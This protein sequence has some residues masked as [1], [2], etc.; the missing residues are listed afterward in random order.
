MKEADVNVSLLIPTMNRSDFLIR[1]LRYYRDL[2]FQGCICIGDS[3]EPEHV[4]RTKRVIKALQDEINI[5]Y[6]EY[7]DLSDPVC[8]QQLLDFVPTPYAAYVA[9]DDFL[10]PSALERCARFLHSHPDYSAA[11][12]VAAVFSLQS[13]GAHGQIM[14]ADR[15]R[16]PVIE[17]GSASQRLVD[18]LG[19]YSVA[20]FSVHPIEAWEAEHRNISL[21]T[22]TSFAGE[23]LPGCLSVI[24][25]KVKELDCLYLVRQDH[26]RRYLLPGVI[27][28]ITSPDWLP[29]YQI[30]RDR[31]AEELAQQDKISIE[32]AQNVV[33]QAFGSYLAKG[34]GKQLEA[35]NAQNGSG[36]RSRSRGVARS[37][38]GITWA[39]HN[40]RSFLPGDNNKKSFPALMRRSSPYHADFMPIYRAITSHPSDSTHD[41]AVDQ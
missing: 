33:K 10:V 18:H 25:G 2:G 5:V 16:Q 7:P 34:L 23:L 28:W 40:F 35:R 29:S 24:Q 39:W 14:G 11:H 32:D 8:L 22:D 36:L 41:A 37:I 19:D 3:S 15:Y 9:D 20:K 26:T 17:A 30:F 6:Q 27:D 12:G 31:L 13:S 1:L 4:E 21:I 38:P